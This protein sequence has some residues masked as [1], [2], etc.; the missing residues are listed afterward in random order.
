MKK[1][2]LSD[3]FLN[4]ATWI[5]SSIGIIILVLIYLFIFSNG[6]QLI[7]KDFI[8]NDY[9]S[10][11]SY[12]MVDNSKLNKEYPK[13][14]NLSDD[15]AYSSKLGIGLVDYT[16][17]DS[18]TVVLVEYIAPDSVFSNVTDEFEPDN[19]VNIEVGMDLN[20]I[21]YS[22]NNTTYSTGSAKENSAQEVIDNLDKATSI[23]QVFIKTIGGGIRGSIV[24]TLITIL[25]SVSLCIPISIA[26]AIY[27]NEYSSKNKVT[28]LMR[29]GIELLSGVPS[30][31]FGLVG[32]VVFYP[33][34]AQMNASGNSILLGSLTM[35]IV[36]LPVAIR[37]C[38]E[39]LKVVPDSLRE[40]SL[41]LGCTKTQ[42]IFKVV[43]PSS[44]SGILTS[45][46]LSIGRVIG[47]SAALVYTMGT[48][49][50]DHPSLTS[51]G[52][53]LSVQIYKEMSGEQPNVQLACAISII[54]LVMVI[55][56]NVFVK[57]LSSRISKKFS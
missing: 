25:V 55:I 31:I 43:I 2:K 3:I 1:N 42:T 32:V 52:T 47:E 34:V 9:W 39:A 17:T 51:T 12:V 35:V 33:I 19:K 29:S 23:D 22:I 37:T 53:T 26:A 28:A 54:I 27:L 14:S 40:A 8:L 57:L 41:S 7:S 49:F 15:V 10:K 6:S 5:T 56:I 20:K 45:V 46:V 24:T 48:I 38:E 16:T 30:I 4:I 36:L 11:T 18:E 13:P 21:T 44:I 50:N